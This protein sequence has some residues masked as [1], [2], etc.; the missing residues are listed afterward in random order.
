MKIT[1]A[2]MEVLDGDGHRDKDHEPIKLK[3]D[4][5]LKVTRG[6][7]G[8]MQAEIRRHI[9]DAE[10]AMDEGQETG[11]NLILLDWFMVNDV[12]V[13]IFG[14]VIKLSGYM[15]GAKGARRDGESPYGHGKGNAYMDVDEALV[16][17]EWR[18]Q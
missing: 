5:D 3:G 6:P 9:L 16:R 4:L 17:V 14:E 1:K 15:N 18:L 2:R 11:D 13:T 8:R 10:R 12:D 7:G